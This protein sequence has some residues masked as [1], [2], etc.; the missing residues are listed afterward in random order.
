MKPSD[1]LVAEAREFAK[2]QFGRLAAPLVFA[3]AFAESKLEAQRREIAAGLENLAIE[4][5]D[6]DEFSEYFNAYIE[7]LRG[8]APPD[9][10]DEIVAPTGEQE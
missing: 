4:A 3:A 1:A 2:V 7:E 6:D 8:S 5:G 9:P 10:V